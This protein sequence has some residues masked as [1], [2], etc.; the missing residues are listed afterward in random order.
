MNSVIGIRLVKKAVLMVWV[1]RV[2]V[3]CKF[4]D[5]IGSSAGIRVIVRVRI[6]E[7]LRRSVVSIAFTW[8][9]TKMGGS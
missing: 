6:M 3:F 1:M 9:C 2:G 7:V 4:F 8:I 5:S